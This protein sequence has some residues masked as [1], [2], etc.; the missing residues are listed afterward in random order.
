[1]RKLNKKGFTLIELLAVI[2][3]LGILMI[4]AIPMVTRYIQQSRQDTFVDTA[5]AYV[6]AA[7]YAFLNGDMN[8]AADGNGTECTLSDNTKYYVDYKGLKVDN[9]GGKSSFGNDI[10]DTGSYVLVSVSSS[11]EITYSTCMTDGKYATGNGDIKKET[12]L[13]RTD[14]KPKAS[15]ASP[16]TSVYTRCYPKN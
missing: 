8:T 1:M 12:E 6:N 14:V 11:G 10:Q 9:T 13:K 15:C 5:K 7:R 3:I 2:V 4:V 16:D